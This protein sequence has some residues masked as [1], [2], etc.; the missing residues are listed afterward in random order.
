MV[1]ACRATYQD[2]ELQAP[3]RT[4]VDWSRLFRLAK[5]HRVEALCWQS[6][7]QFPERMPAAVAE[8]FTKRSAITVESNLR[9]TAECARLRTK[10]EQEEVRLLFLKGLTLGSLAYP[11]PFLKMSWDIDLLVEGNQLEQAFRLLRTIGYHPTVP[12]DADDE[13]LKRWHQNSKES[14]WFSDSGNFTLDLHNRVADNPAM[15]PGLGVNSPKRQVA[16][17]VGIELPTFAKDELFAYLCAHGASS[18]WFRLKW[19]ADLAALL[20]HELPDELERLYE[21]SQQLGAGRAADQALLL[22]ADVFEIMLPGDLLSHLRSS[23]TGRWLAHLAKRQL[24]SETEPT[25]RLLGTAA[26]HY[27]QPFLMSSWQFKWTEI[28]RQARAVMRNS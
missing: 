26:I 12:N 13:A 3:D 19:L 14:V 22:A 10:F 15:L 20:Q 7:A 25:A 11:R 16:I 24:A 17:A 21:R 6:L 5:R 9:S 27:S 8:Q 4:L 28:A 1:A 2:A 23:R 18:A